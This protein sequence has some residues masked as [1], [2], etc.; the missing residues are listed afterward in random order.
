MMF[1]YSL[2]LLGSS[3]VKALKFFLYYVV[4]WGICVALLL[5]CFFEFKTLLS[6]GLADIGSSLGGVFTGGLGVGLHNCILAV[7]DTFVKA[8]QTNVG[9]VVYG[10]L[11]LFILVPFLINIG[12]YAFCQMLYS[13]M[14]SK[15]KVGFFSALVKGLRRSVFFALFKTL[16][17][18]LFIVLTLGCVYGLALVSDPTF[19]AHILP[20]ALFASMVLLFTLHEVSILGWLPA[21]IVFNCNAFLAWHKGFKAVKRHF[22]PTFGTTMLYF[23]LFWALT[24]VF[25]IY[26]LVVLIPFVTI[27]LCFYNMVMFFFS[28]GMRF[29]Y[30]EN[31]ILT[32]KKLEEVD[33]FSNAIS[34]L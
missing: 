29:Y 15:N 4:I 33:K 8:I 16:F 3:W 30:N 14:T 31:N 5:P 22:W 6:A 27:M 17:A 18:D 25:G 20:W 34:L 12:K 24:L 21:S 28:Q 23:I 1:L 13:Y 19:V 2:K 26:C 11:V 9:L 7:A 32:P 10:L